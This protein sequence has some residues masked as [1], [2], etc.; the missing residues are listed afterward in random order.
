MKRIRAFTLIEL[1]VVV[2]IVALLVAILIPALGR[3]REQAKRTT[4]ATN[5]R[6]QGSSISLY[7][8]GNNDRLPWTWNGAGNSNWLWDEPREFSETV[9]NLLPNQRNNMSKISLRKMFYCPTNQDQNI[10]G[11]WSFSSSSVLGYSYFNARSGT[12]GMSQNPTLASVVQ[13]QG[14][15]NPPITFKDKYTNNQF[16]SQVE[17][18]LDAI[19][20]N[21][22]NFNTIAPGFW[23]RI[24][25]GFPTPHYSSH[26][27]KGRPTGANVLTFDNSVTWKKYTPPQAQKG[28]KWV[29]SGGGLS[30]GPYFWVPDPHQ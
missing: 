1:L 13:G 22:T 2:A 28:S 23:D 11:L 30:G 6:A 4:C 20:S 8:A 19:L 5:I 16:G 9:L 24:Q 3:V 18:I 7:A 15:R 29:G 17:L 12:F 14:G 21:G 27:A 25:G 10:D 26:L